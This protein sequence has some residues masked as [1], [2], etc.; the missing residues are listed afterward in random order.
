MSADN[1]AS[2]VVL[3]SIQSGYDANNGKMC[4]ISQGYY[5]D[6]ETAIMGPGAAT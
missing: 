4:D 2:I 6:E 1:G 5:K 3:A